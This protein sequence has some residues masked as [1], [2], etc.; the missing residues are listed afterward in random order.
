L[1]DIDVEEIKLEY[2]RIICKIILYCIIELPINYGITKTIAILRG[3]HSIFMIDHDL[4]QAN[5]G[6]YSMLSN[7]NTSQIREI[8]NLLI[9]SN[10]IEYQH[11]KK[12]ELPVLTVSKKGYAFLCNEDETNIRFMANIVQHDLPQVADD[13]TDLFSIL[14]NLRRQIAR[15]MEVPAYSICR[16]R[17]LFELSESKPTTKEELKVIHGIGNTFIDKFGE[18]FLDIINNHTTDTQKERKLINKTLLNHNDSPDT[19]IIGSDE[20]QPDKENIDSA[21]LEKEFIKILTKYLNERERNIVILRLGLGQRNGKILEEIG[22]EYNLTRERIRQIL[23]KAYR[24]LRHPSRN[25][26][27]PEYFEILKFRRDPKQYD[28]LFYRLNRNLNHNTIIKPA[29]FTEKEDYANIEEHVKSNTILS[30]I[31]L[32]PID[33]PPARAGEPWDT[34][35][36]NK[37]VKLFDEGTS[38]SALADIHQRYTG[39]IEA[40][41]KKLGK[42]A[43]A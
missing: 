3:S 27:I 26:N 2:E 23:N 12:F 21:A 11:V 40:R 34:A 41:L 15:E 13:D 25:L 10:L 37:L 4:K 17:V 31:K 30:D 43:Y 7:F 5:L 36:D 28:E 8:I 38:I 32:A 16:D 20:V 6:T 42:L 19:E 35:E 39:A 18:L 9:K 1:Q 33:V 24:K 22:K 14:R 29:S